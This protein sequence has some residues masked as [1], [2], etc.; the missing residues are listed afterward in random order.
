MA[1]AATEAPDVGAIFA[2]MRRGLW[3]PACWGFDCGRRA[4]ER[5]D[6]VAPARLSAR[7]SQTQSS[8]VI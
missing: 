7:L 6:H 1:E 8:L 2:E 4:A 3:W 5:G